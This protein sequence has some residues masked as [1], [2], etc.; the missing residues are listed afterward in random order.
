M[1][2][3]TLN[4]TWC[5]FT[6]YEDYKSE[7]PEN[8]RLIES[9][10]VFNDYKEQLFDKRILS[11][12]RRWRDFFET[13]LLPFGFDLIDHLII[14]GDSKNANRK[15]DC[16][17]FFEN[18]VE[19]TFQES[20]NE[21]LNFLETIERLHK[22][23][24]KDIIEILALFDLE[25]NYSMVMLHDKTKYEADFEKQFES[26]EMVFYNIFEPI[27]NYLTTHFKGFDIAKSDF[28]SGELKIFK[29]NIISS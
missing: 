4:L 29:S 25:F 19:I 6:C 5:S 18:T 7:F 27:R 15:F 8:I 10:P 13:Y 14:V 22:I 16:F 24:S 23:I 3:R 9:R 20:E 1:S 26:K 17:G 28:I 11:S 12:N 21:L 2:E